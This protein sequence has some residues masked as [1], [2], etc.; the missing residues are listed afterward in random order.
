MDSNVHVRFRFRALAHETSSLTT[1]V[2][3]ERKIL[4]ASALQLGFW[5]QPLDNGEKTAQV[6]KKIR[7]LEQKNTSL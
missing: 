4:P 7:G 3:L 5:K 2:S 6:K 1:K